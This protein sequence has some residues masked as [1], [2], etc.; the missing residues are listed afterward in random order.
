MK[1]L[2][3]EKYAASTEDITI[4]PKLKEIIESTGFGFYFKPF[5]ES[6]PNCK[7]I[8]YNTILGKR[9][10]GLTDEIL[11][12][13][14]D[15]EKLKPEQII[16][17]ENEK[18]V[19]NAI[20]TTYMQ[21]NGDL[22]KKSKIER[23]VMLNGATLPL[24]I[25]ILQ[26]GLINDTIYVKK[27]DTNRIIGWFLYNMIRNTPKNRFGFNEKLFIEEEV[28]GHTLLQEDDQMMFVIDEYREGIGRAAAHSEFLGLFEDVIAERNRIV[29]NNYNTILFDFD[30]ILEPRPVGERG[31]H[32]MRYY[33]EE[34]K[35]PLVKVDTIMVNAYRDEKRKIAER[36][37]ANK[38]IILPFAQ[39][40]NQMK[41]PR[42][43]NIRNK[44]GE[45]SGHKGLKEYIIYQT[46]VF[47]Q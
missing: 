2:Y 12:H 21:I 6:R 29:D 22:P 30:A 8:G 42:Y 44:V 9:I 23:I 27:P 26:E 38:N 36:I 14:E 40:A 39:I 35:S 11:A 47:S 17:S 5:T 43:G 10:V 19:E 45:F 16:K 28:K 4:P 24:K 37:A 15:P 18:E 33:A 31:N 32:I 1:Q 7:D 3:F 20:R 13:K 46:R 34:A 25:N 41:D